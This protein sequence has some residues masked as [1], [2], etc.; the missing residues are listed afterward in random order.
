MNIVLIFNILSVQLMLILY[1]IHYQQ[2][3]LFF[4][5]IRDSV[6][7]ILF[8]QDNEEKSVATLIL[9]S[10]LQVFYL[11]K[12]FSFKEKFEIFFLHFLYI[13]FLRFYKDMLV[14]FKSLITL[15]S[16]LVELYFFSSFFA[17]LFCFVF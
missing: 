15:S 17:I 14:V 5:L 2:G 16:L 6:V 13:L 1:H 4:N 8:E 9:D 3:A 7:E 10:L 12:S 11:V